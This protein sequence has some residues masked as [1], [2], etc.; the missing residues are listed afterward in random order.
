MGRKCRVT[1]CNGNYDKQNEESTFRLPSDPEEKKCWLQTIPRDN[2]PL[3]KG[4]AMCVEDI[5]KKNIHLL[6]ALENRD[7]GIHQVN[8]FA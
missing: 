2:I 7:Q 1:G 3:T 5:G 4:T 8:S 6:C